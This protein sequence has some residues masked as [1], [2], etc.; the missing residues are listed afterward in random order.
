MQVA[1]VLTK[2]QHHYQAVKIG[3]ETATVIKM[4]IVVPVSVTERYV[5]FCTA[6]GESRGL[7]DPSI[8]QPVL[9]EVFIELSAEHA[10]RL[11]SAEG[12]P[13]G[14]GIRATVAAA[15]EHAVEQIIELNAA[16]LSEDPHQTARLVMRMEP[17]PKT[18]QGVEK[19]VEI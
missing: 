7:S 10:V 12:I 4:G 18:A 5:L 6:C 14:D 8:G 1:P 11:I 16:W 9:T 19:G 2:H 17:A 15:V 13:V 3:T